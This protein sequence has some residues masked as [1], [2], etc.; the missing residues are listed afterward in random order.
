MDFKKTLGLINY[1]NNNEYYQKIK[2]LG[3]EYEI[4]I[5]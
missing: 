3:F 5:A 1:L 2:S 4:Q